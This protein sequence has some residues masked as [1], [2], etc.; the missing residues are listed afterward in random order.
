MGRIV[1]RDRD[2]MCLQNAK[3]QIKELIKINFAGPFAGQPC[4]NEYKLTLDLDAAS[5]RALFS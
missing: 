3:C 4:D 2:A 1:K 5:K